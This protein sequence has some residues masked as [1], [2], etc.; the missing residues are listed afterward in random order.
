MGSGVQCG[1]ENVQDEARSGRL[2]LVKED[3]LRKVNESE[4]DDRRFTISDPHLHFSQIS[5]TLLYDIVSSHFG[6]GRPHSIRRVYIK[7]VPS[8]NKC[9]KNGGKHVQK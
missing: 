1:T 9:L 2:S 8:Y 7:L 4:R 5:R 6:Y 3:S